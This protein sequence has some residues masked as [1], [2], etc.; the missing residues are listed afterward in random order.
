M[1]YKE[2]ELISQAQIEESPSSSSKGKSSSPFTDEWLHF[3]PGSSN[4]QSSN[5]HDFRDPYNSCRDA[6]VA[7]RNESKLFWYFYK[8][9]LEKVPISNPWNINL[10]KLIIPEVFIDIDLK[11][12]LIKEYNPTSKA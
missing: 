12:V 8:N 7:D 11:K 6:K 2:G 3:L 10:G 4:L 9:K 5:D 1:E